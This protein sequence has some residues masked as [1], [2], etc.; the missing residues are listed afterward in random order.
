MYIF[1]NKLNNL[2]KNGWTPEEAVDYMK[3]KRQHILIHKAQWQALRTF[4]DDQIKS[5]K[6]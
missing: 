3:S 5:A 1:T 6:S 2:Q 4:Y